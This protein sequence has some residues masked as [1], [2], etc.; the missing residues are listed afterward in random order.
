MESGRQIA[1]QG[2][3]ERAQT[4]GL[5]CKK[6]SPHDVDTPRT[7]SALRESWWRIWE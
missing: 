2:T 6:A 3:V 7:C 5:S 4:F 1:Y